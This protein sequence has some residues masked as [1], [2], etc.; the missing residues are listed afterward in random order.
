MILIFAFLNLYIMMFLQT[1][2]K[3]NDVF[4]HPSRLHQMLVTETKLI[5]ASPEKPGSITVLSYW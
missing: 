4:R 1:G 5:T 2:T 3:Y